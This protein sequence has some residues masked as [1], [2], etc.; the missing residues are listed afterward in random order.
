ML[1]FTERSQ[2]VYSQIE[3]LKKDS[4]D[5]DLYAKKLQKRGHLERAKKILQKREFILRTLEKVPQAT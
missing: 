3:R 5:L 4:N 1:F 2:M